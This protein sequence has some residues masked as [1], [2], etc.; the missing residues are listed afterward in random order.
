MGEMLVF[1]YVATASAA[2]YERMV[3]FAV[4]LS[5]EAGVELPICKASSYAELTQLV[6]HRKV[7]IAWLPP[8]PFIALERF[9]LVAPLATV[10]RG[11]SSAFFSVVIV[12]ADSALSNPREL[13]GKRAAWVDP[14]SASGYVLPRIGFMAVG[15]DPRTAF[16]SERFYGSH[17][18][19]VRAVIEGR[20]DFGGAYAGVDDTGLVTRAPWL[21]LPGA[22]DA[23]RVLATFGAIPADV[24]VARKGLD[25][26]TR[27][28]VA[29]A[30]ARTGEQEENC[31]LLR[32]VFG[33]DAFV[34]WA[35]TTVPTDGAPDRAGYAEFRQATMEA[36]NQGLVDGEE[37]GLTS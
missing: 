12:A 23:V 4:A 17:E 37:K 16:R 11:G 3:S 14:H 1:G 24:I 2:P 28:M 6:Q 22:E 33:A 26:R 27:E 19:V 35:D 13:R 8:L 30:L 36:S 5:R 34:P 9:D 15:L 10:Q 7:D 31:P 20:A 29:G 18:A 21:E 25:A 32:E